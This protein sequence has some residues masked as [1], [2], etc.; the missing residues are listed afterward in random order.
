MVFMKTVVCTLVFHCYD[1]YTDSVVI[2]QYYNTSNSRIIRSKLTYGQ[3]IQFDGWAGENL[4]RIPDLDDSAPSSEIGSLMLRNVFYLISF[5]SFLLITVACV[6]VILIIPSIPSLHSLLHTSLQMR[7]SVTENG[8]RLKEAKIL[9]R[10]N[11]VRS[12]AGTESSCN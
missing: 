5:L 10:F 7:S 12:E 6:S 4:D 2:Y 11:F 3:I 1:Y 9:T 8:N